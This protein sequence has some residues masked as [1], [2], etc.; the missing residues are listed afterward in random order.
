[1]RA[2]VPLSTLLDGG[3]GVQVVATGSVVAVVVA[4][5][6]IPG[7]L[8]WPAPSL[9]QALPTLGPSLHQSVCSTSH[10]MGGPGSHPIMVS[11]WVPAVAQRLAPQ[12]SKPTIDEEVEWRPQAF[13]VRWPSSS[14]SSPPLTT[15][16]A[17]FS[18][19]KRLIASLLTSFLF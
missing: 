16:T 12:G 2:T 8:L 9:F 13:A 15:L 3:T 14:S 1:M 6:C 4:T 11:T 10:A 17:K 5:P 18:L 19:H 7:D